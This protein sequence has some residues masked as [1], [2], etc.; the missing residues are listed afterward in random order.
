MSTLPEIIT[1]NLAAR[2][3]AHGSTRCCVDSSAW[4]ITPRAPRGA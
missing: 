4:R 2:H 3:T 1:Q